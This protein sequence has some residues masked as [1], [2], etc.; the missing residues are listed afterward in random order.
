M[1]EAEKICTK[2]WNNLCDLIKLGREFAE[3]QQDISRDLEIIKRSERVEADHKLL[4]MVVRLL[5]WWRQ[6]YREYPA[7]GHCE[8]HDQTDV[9]LNLPEIIAILEKE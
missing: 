7:T 9:L 4:V 3:Q 8:E 2:D 5:D 6:D 1:S